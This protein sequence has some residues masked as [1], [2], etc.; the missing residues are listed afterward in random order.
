MIE[1]FEDIERKL[2]NIQP[3]LKKS[4]LL[5]FAEKQIQKFPEVGRIENDLIIKR[6]HSLGQPNFSCF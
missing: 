3:S 1:S 5:K 2:K 6:F 4:N